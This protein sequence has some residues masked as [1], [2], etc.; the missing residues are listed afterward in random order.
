MYHHTGYRTT[1]HAVCSEHLRCSKPG[2]RVLPSTQ[3]QLTDIF[4]HR[5]DRKE[6]H[7]RRR[8]LQV[9]DP[10]Q[11]SRLLP[12]HS[13]KVLLLQLGSALPLE[14]SAWP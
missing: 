10:G 13:K 9:S 1:K 7:R 2:Y 11:T 4:S 14:T 3:R 6:P 5:L 12:I 8:S